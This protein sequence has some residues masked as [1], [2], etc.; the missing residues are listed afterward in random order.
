MKKIIVLGILILIMIAPVAAAIPTLTNE[1][2]TSTKQSSGTQQEFTHT[3]LAE[4]GTTTTCPYCVTASSQ[5]Y[6]IY[7]SGDLDFY[8][9]SLVYDTGNMNVRQRLQQLGVSSI[10][11]VHFDGGYKRVLGAQ[12]DEQAYRN[13]ISQCGLRAVPD[14]DMQVD[15]EW[16]GGGTLKI[17]V[18]VVNNEPEEYNGH[19]RVY[20]VEKTSRWNDNGGNPYHFGVLDIPIDRSL[21]LESQQQGSP[22]PLG[23]TY[24]FKKTWFGA[25]FGFS[26]ITN[27]NTMVIASVFDPD[28]KFTVQTTAATP[29]TSGV[30]SF[31]PLTQTHQLLA[32]IKMLYNQILM[33]IFLNH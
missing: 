14:L 21:S 17:T 25:L 3:V 8:Y 32:P 11:D 29:T 31:I 16:K 5:L 30:P 6:S 28:S 19:L 15:V 2:K 7:N 18:T 33:R 9:V 22:R 10:P 12:N 4:Y 26:D 1:I 13:A 24:T 27:E 23:E 20:V